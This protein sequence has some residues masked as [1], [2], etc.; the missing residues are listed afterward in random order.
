MYLRGRTTPWPCIKDELLNLDLNISFR[1][2]YAPVS[3]IPPSDY[4]FTGMQDNFHNCLPN[5]DQI[6]GDMNQHSS[7]L[8]HDS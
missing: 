8:I 3:S 6:L 1:L 5:K 2:Q 4:N 7:I